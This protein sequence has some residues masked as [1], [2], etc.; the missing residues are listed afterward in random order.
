M[1]KR[2]RCFVLL[3]FVLANISAI[4]C[5]FGVPRD[6]ITTRSLTNLVEYLRFHPTPARVIRSAISPAFLLRIYTIRRSAYDFL[7]RLGLQ[8]I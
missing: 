3:V 7:I 6:A 4:L 2:I 5:A 8:Y 1:L